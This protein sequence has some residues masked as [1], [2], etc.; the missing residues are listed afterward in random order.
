MLIAVLVVTDNEFQTV[1]A[2]LVKQYDSKSEDVRGR[3]R[4]P[5]SDDHKVLVGW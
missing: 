1:G 3:Y 2:A 5:V 4:S